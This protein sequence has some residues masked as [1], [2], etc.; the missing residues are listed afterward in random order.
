MSARQ[1]PSEEILKRVFE[2]LPSDPDEAIPLRSV[3]PNLND[4]ISERLTGFVRERRRLTARALH[5]LI[6]RGY[7]QKLKI[8]E[9]VGDRQEG[10]VRTSLYYRLGETYEQGPR[11]IEGGISF[12]RKRERKENVLRPGDD[13]LLRLESK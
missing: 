3:R 5:I 4:L 2:S 12:E 11:I 7:V 13:N 8:D 10:I 9:R 6:E 1:Q